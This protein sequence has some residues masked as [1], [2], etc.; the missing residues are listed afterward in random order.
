MVTCTMVVPLLAVTTLCML[1]DA[2][3]RNSSIT[4]LDLANNQLWG[5]RGAQQIRDML[6][7]SPS[8]QELLLPFCG[9]T[10]AGACEI[11]RGASQS[12]SLRRLDLSQNHIGDDVPWP[13]YSPSGDGSAA[14]VNPE[15]RAVDLSFNWI[16]VIHASS[17]S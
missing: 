7:C 2:L 15:M 5:V 4:T 16:Q 17:I 14:H 9:I 13:A 10:S 6:V 12:K 1:S 8:L 11:V 3:S